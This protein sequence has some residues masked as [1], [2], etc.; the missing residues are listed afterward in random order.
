[1]TAAK[2]GLCQNQDRKWIIKKES[3]STVCFKEYGR[4]RSTSKLLHF[5]KRDAL[6]SKYLFRR[7]RRRGKTI[8]FLIRE[9][10]KIT[11]VSTPE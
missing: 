9:L 7:S 8:N 11:D 3:P 5:V 6:I 10:N 4:Y 2:N 1:M